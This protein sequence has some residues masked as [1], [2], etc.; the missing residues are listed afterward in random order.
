MSQSSFLSLSF[1]FCRNGDVHS[2]FPRLSGRLW[3]MLLTKCS[4]SVPGHSEVLCNDDGKVD[5]GG[6]GGAGRPAV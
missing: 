2:T 5:L 4:G 3:E 1:L 6:E